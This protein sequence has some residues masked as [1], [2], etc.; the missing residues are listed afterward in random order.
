MAGVRYLRA[1]RNS[2]ARRPNHPGGGRLAGS[3]VASVYPLREGRQL[4]WPAGVWALMAAGV[5][6]LVVLGLCEARHSGRSVA[7]LL[8]AQLFRVPAFAA[9][10]GIQ[11]A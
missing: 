1:T 11:L 4:G 3:L 8:R 2:A 9:G 10:M 7:P 5:A 6:G